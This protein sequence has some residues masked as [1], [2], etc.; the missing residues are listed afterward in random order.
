[1]AIVTVCCVVSLVS[2]TKT[3]KEVVETHD[4]V[5]Q[6]I[7]KKDSTSEISHKTDT[8]YQFRTDTFEKVT[9]KY[10]SIIKRD[11]VY[12]KDKGDTVVIYKEHWNTKVNIKTDTVYKSKTDTVYKVKTDTVKIIRFVERN[13]SSY[14]SSDKDKLK[15]KQK[16]T[17]LN[18][19]IIG[20]IILLLGTL[21]WGL[22]MLKK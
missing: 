15:V 17:W 5:F 11:S 14:H 1:M 10:D 3:V 22:K 2:C 18:I 12:V 21:I 6:D 8:V 4:T 19:G 20:G 16:R 9:V 7:E 13:D